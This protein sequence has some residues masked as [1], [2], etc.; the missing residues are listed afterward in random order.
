MAIIPAFSSDAKR[1]LK[2]CET[3]KIYGNCEMC[4]DK[5]ETAGI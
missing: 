3:V 1:K 4:K 2:L 5:I